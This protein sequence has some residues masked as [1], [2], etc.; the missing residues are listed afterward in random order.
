MSKYLIINADDFGISHAE[1]LAVA[2]LYQSG[3]I[4]SAS[5]MA[6]AH[7]YNEAV[8]IAKEIQM[9]SVGVHLYFTSEYPNDGNIFSLKSQTGSEALMKDGAFTPDFTFDKAD[10]ALLSEII[11]EAEYQIEMVKNDGIKI[12]HLDNHMYSLWPC[13]G[14]DFLDNALNLCNQYNIPT[15]RLSV[16]CSE[17]DKYY[18]PVHASR[19]RRLAVR[20]S[21]ASAKVKTA[22][23]IYLMQQGKNA[24]FSDEQML[25]N[26]K[27]FVRRLTNGISEV[28]LHPAI[29][30]EE[31]QKY[32]PWYVERDA[33][34]RLLRDNDIKAICA[35]YGVKLIS[36]ADLAK[37]KRFRLPFAKIIRNI[38]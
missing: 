11:K 20:A 26:F 6:G 16:G 9:D 34:Y 1:N 33:E 12:S 8:S 25:E 2:E 24:D 38:L 22:D 10:P 19:R 29:A 15:I 30:S 27:N 3:K 5:I 37:M 21:A 32:N 4:T 7:A 14:A 36:Y 23:Y 35:E 28:H 13:R 17:Q 18:S 31:Q